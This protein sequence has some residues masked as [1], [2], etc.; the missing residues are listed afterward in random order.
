MLKHLASGIEDMVVLDS[1]IGTEIP[2]YA[3]VTILYHI[4]K[5]FFLMGN[6]RRIG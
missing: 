6:R 1:P 2:P 4:P 3:T 5:Q